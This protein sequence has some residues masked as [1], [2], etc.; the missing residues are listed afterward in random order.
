M[1]VSVKHSTC[2]LLVCEASGISRDYGFRSFLAKR[3]THAVGHD[4]QR[5]FFCWYDDILTSFGGA[6]SW[7]LTRMRLGSL[8]YVNLQRF[9][10]PLILSVPYEYNS[11]TTTIVRMLS[12]LLGVIRQLRGGEAL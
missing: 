11:C 9:Y 5:Y 2:C 10:I 6:C 12:V 8:M 7:L 3:G 1:F 4:L